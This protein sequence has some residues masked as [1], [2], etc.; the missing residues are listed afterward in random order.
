[1]TDVHW[2]KLTDKR[3]D[4]ST[5]SQLQSID[6]KGLFREMLQPLFIKSSFGEVPFIHCLAL[7]SHPRQQRRCKANVSV[8]LFTNHVL[9]VVE[10][11]QKEHS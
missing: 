4:Y 2:Y 8:A 3:Q 5:V 11:E 9:E 6:S 10:S 7:F 1:M